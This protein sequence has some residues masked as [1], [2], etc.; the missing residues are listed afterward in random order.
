MASLSAGADETVA[1]EEVDERS[2]SRVEVRVEAP[3]AFAWTPVVVPRRYDA[4]GLPD[5][6]RE[7][8]AVH[9]A[10]EAL[11]AAVDR[12][13]ADTGRDAAAVAWHAEPVVQS[14]C[15]T[16]GATIAGVRV[17]EDNFI[18]IAAEVPGDEDLR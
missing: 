15:S 14:F 12:L 13:D 7:T 6:L 10:V 18:V 3:P 2:P 17:S 8:A 5:E 9:A 1:V 11:R 16:Y 4:D